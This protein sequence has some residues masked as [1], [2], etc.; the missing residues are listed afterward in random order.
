MKRRGF[1]GALVAAPFAG[2]ATAEQIAKQSKIATGGLVPRSD[3]FNYMFTTP[4]S[5]T[6]DKEMWR[7]AF[8]LFPA[9]RNERESIFFAEETVSSIDPD[10]AVYRSFSLNA[11]IAYQRQRNVAHKM[12]KL[13]QETSYEQAKGIANR[14]LSLLSPSGKVEKGS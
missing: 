10:I 11:K 2:R 9:L 1:L 4:G 12:Q 13:Q 6:P 7:E 8:E 14:V 3:V 5:R